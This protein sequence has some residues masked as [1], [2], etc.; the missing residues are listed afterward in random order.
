MKKSKILLSALAFVAFLVLYSC[1]NIGFKVTLNANGGLFDNAAPTY[2]ITTDG[3]EVIT[4][5]KLPTREGFVLMGWYL[6]KQGTRPADELLSRP[7]TENVTL[8]AKWGYQIEFETN[9]GK[10]IQPLKAA[11]GESITAPQA[12]KSGYVL[13]GW[14]T[15]QELEEEF[16]FDKMPSQHIKLYAKWRLFNAGLVFEPVDG[17]ENELQVKLGNCLDSHIRI[18]AEYDGK[19]VT[20]IPQYGFFDVNGFVLSITIPES[21]NSIHIPRAIVCHKLE[22]IYV[23][24][25]NQHYRSIDG[26]L[27]YNG[28]NGLALIRYPSGKPGY[29]YAIPDNENVV[30]IASGAFGYSAYLNMLAIPRSVNVIGEYQFSENFYPKVIFA[31]ADSKPEGWQANCFEEHL[32]VFGSELSPERDRVISFTKTQN[33]FMNSGASPWNNNFSL[34]NILSDNDV[35]EGWYTDSNF[36]GQKVSNLYAA[37][38][39]T[40]LYAKWISKTDTYILDL[41]WFKA[42]EAFTYLW[43]GSSSD[44]NFEDVLNQS[45]Q[46]IGWILNANYEDYPVIAFECP[47]A[48]YDEVYAAVLRKNEEI[49]V[50]TRYIPYPD[51]NIYVAEDCSVKYIFDLDFMRVEDSIFNK[52]RTVLLRQLYLG[53]QGYVF[54]APQELKVISPRAF[55]QRTVKKVILNNVETVMDMA[56]KSVGLTELIMSDNLKHIGNLAFSGNYEYEGEVTIP[57]SVE[58]IG[59]APFFWCERITAINVDENNSHYKSIDGSLYTKDGTILIQY[60]P[61]RMGDLNVPDSVVTIQEYALVYTDVTNLSIGKNVAE[62][63]G[64]IPFDEMYHLVSISVQPDNQHFKSID[65]HLYSKDGKTFIKYATAADGVLF[66]IP[67]SVEKIDKYA[68]RDCWKLRHLILG[69]GIQTFKSFYLYFDTVIV[70]KDSPFDITQDIGSYTIFV[71]DY[72]CTLGYDGGIPYV[73]A[74]TLPGQYLLGARNPYRQG[75]TFAGWYTQYNPQTGEY[76]G[77]KYNNTSDLYNAPAGTYY[78]K[79]EAN[80]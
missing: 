61:G 57:A 75:Y 71:E 33:S 29:F 14:Y 45:N 40:K 1:S 18:P 30:E 16:V 41:I 59:I 54:E 11:A 68:F 48:N 22:A 15:D 47:P 70:P 32:A 7:I 38:D 24:P 50:S 64:N 8:Y 6:D 21:I 60:P 17:K 67:D 39:G 80:T 20:Y 72:N 79:W 73:T 62:I 3:N 37:N 35:L 58:S 56:F 52:D 10:P 44:F 74:L 66:V 4:I 27:Y 5:D 43:G 25:D 76:S 2:T 36:S 9:G 78:A 49:G 19:P 55:T 12:E 13:D 65:G 53:T 69:S 42:R 34:S 63:K 77:Q 23:H 51:T 28:E 31:E 26:C 46:K